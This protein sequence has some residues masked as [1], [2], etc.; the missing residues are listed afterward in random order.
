MATERTYRLAEVISQGFE[1]RCVT[2]DGTL[3]FWHRTYGVKINKRT[4]K[5]VLLTDPSVLPDALWTATR[6]GLAEMSA[7]QGQPEADAAA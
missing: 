1:A 4:G 6:L 3:Y 7:A 5:A 2:R